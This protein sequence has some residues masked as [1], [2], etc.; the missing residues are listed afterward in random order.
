MVD[1][2]PIRRDHLWRHIWSGQTI[3][4]II[5]D[6]G[7]PSMETILDLGGPSLARKI[8]TDGLG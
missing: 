5:D 3:Y 4:G 7:R 8:A 1:S 2:S 6:S